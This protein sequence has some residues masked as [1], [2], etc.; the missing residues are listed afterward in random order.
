MSPLGRLPLALLCV[1]VLLTS[2]VV[3]G[4]AHSGPHRPHMGSPSEDR[5]T[6]YWDVEQ[7][8]W[9]PNAWGGC[10]E[11]QLFYIDPNITG[12]VRTAIRAGIAAWDLAKYCGPDW[13]ET[14]AGDPQFGLRVRLGNTA[15]CVTTRF[16]GVACL[17]YAHSSRQQHWTVVL[18]N[19][20]FAFGVQTANRMDYQSIM[21]NEMGHVM[22]VGHNPDWLDSVVQANSC[23]WGSTTCDPSPTQG[24][25]PPP[26]NCDNCGDRRRL[27]AGDTALMQHIYGQSCEG[28]RPADHAPSSGEQTV[29]DSKEE[30]ENTDAKQTITELRDGSISCPTAPGLGLCPGPDPTGLPK[31]AG[32]FPSGVDST[33]ITDSAGGSE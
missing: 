8:N 20:N 6:D 17:D 24:V 27:L 33:L 7:N 30:L 3:P 13:V 1:T 16:I 4:S 5:Y 26:V 22:F 15:S 32:T 10:R 18:N 21:T 14:T 12:S 31:G 11:P 25:D 29:R 9:D 19:V 23:P 28:C 2:G